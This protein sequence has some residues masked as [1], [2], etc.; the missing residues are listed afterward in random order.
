MG[1]KNAVQVNSLSCASAGYCAAG[2]RYRGPEAGQRMQPM[3]AAAAGA[4]LAAALSSCSSSADP[5]PFWHPMDGATQCVPARG[6]KVLT[7]GL[8]VIQNRAMT[9]AVIDKVAFANP[10]GVRVI[11]AYVVP[12]NGSLYGVLYGYPPEGAV[13]LGFT[14]TGFH[15]NR[16]QNAVGAMVPHMT[17]MNLLL[18]FKPLAGIARGTAA[19]IDIWYHVRSTH[20]HFRTKTALVVLTKRRSCF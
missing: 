9:T 19:G 13:D 16:R 1:K 2:G 11:R 5:G 3:R 7:D 10:K 14:V 12:D 17:R 20:Y 6:N 18:V 15:W 4:I 8:E